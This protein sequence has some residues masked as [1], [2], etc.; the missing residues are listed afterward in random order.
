MYELRGGDP[1]HFVLKVENYCTLAAARQPEPATDW[2][3]ISSIGF[4]WVICAC[5]EDP[6]CDPLPLKLLA[7]IRLTDLSDG[8]PPDNPVAE[9]EQIAAV[10]SKAFS[11]LNEGGILVHA[12]EEGVGPGRSSAR[13]CATVGTV[14]LR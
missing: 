9:I 8:C 14:R 5:S 13:S 3:Q 2:K 6:G 1:V 11:K 4:R 10:A 7:R 12:R